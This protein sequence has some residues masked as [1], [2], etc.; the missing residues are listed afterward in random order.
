[1]LLSLALFVS[2]CGGGSSSGSST[3]QVAPTIAPPSAPIAAGLA[4]PPAGTVYFG[5]YVDP[6]GLIH[7]NSL[8][9]IDTLEGQIGRTL[10][11]DNQYLVF[12]SVFGTRNQ[13]DDYQQGRLPL[14]S[15]NCG[16]PNAQIAAGDYDASLR[17]QAD[18]IKA[19]GWPVLVRYMYDPDLPSDQL[20]RS[21]CYDPATDNANGTFSAAEFVAAWQHIHAIFAQEGAVNAVFVWSISSLGRNS[22]AYYPGDSQVDW[23]AMDVYDVADTTFAAT[24]APTYALLAPYGKPIAI[25]ETGADVTTQPAFFAS[26]PATLQSQF[27][28]VRAFVYYDAIGKQ[29]DWRVEP[30]TQAAFTTLGRAS[31][32]GGYYN[33]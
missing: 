24:I 21:G 9:A 13:L 32:M 8:A 31:Y 2:G 11:V 16:P 14:F 33:R 10:A 26:V 23:V 5:A 4:T 29:N 22:L 15:W 30:S 27:P 18:A 1:V 19:Y 12:N 6:S 20:Q 17:G 25:T 28:L 7:G 3:P